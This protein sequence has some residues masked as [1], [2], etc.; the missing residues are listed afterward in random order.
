MID[1]RPHRRVDT[2]FFCSRSAYFRGVKVQISGAAAYV[3]M[4]NAYRKMIAV[5]NGVCSFFFWGGGTAP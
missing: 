4:H 2:I 5:N 1:N 3:N